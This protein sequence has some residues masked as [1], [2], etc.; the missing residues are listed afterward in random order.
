M[1][2]FG[3]VVNPFNIQNIRD[4]YL[5]SKIAPQALIEMITGR[6]PPLKIHHAK[7]LRSPRGI[8]I[9]GWFIA[10]PLLSKQVLAMKEEFVLDKILKSV[11]LG[12]K[13]GAEIIGLGALMGVA[14]RGGQ[15]IAEKTPVAITTGSSLAS[16]AILET[17]DRAAGLRKLDLSRAKVAIV[18][19]TNSIGQNCALGFLN[20]VDTIFLIAKNTERLTELKEFLIAQKTTINVIE[21]GTVLEPFIR[22]ADI[23]IFT[24]SAIEVPSIATAGSL[25]KNA[26]I[27]DIPSPRNIS[28]EICLDREDILV[29]DGAVIEPPQTVKVGLKLPIKDGFIFAC[30]AETMILA[31]EGRTQ[32]DFSTGFKPDLNKVT[33][34]KTLAAKHGFEIKFTSF[35]VPVSG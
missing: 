14:G 27:C 19:A 12:E 35:G 6:M 34:I 16:A 25:K 13:T 11:R 4:H 30:M 21:T 8:T 28:Q 20:R 2:K 24:T 15:V 1:S 22:D 3:F 9:D 5:M 26:I 33:L 23:V 31:F 32:E 10:C 17:L 29:I 18:G 7:N